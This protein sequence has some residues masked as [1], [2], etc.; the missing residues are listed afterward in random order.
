MRCLHRHAMPPLPCN[1]VLLGVYESLR[2]GRWVDSRD[3]D[4]AINRVCEESVLV[5]I[6]VSKFLQSSCQKMRDILDVW[7]REDCSR[8]LK[9]RTTEDIARPER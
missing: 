5:E 8:N 7:I 1:A 2:M 9:D 6:N 3:V 4:A